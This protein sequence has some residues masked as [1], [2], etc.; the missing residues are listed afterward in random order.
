MALE[1][2]PPRLEDSKTPRTIESG[3][4]RE[5]GIVRALPIIQYE[6]MRNATAPLVFLFAALA[7]GCGGGLVGSP[8]AAATWKVGFW[9]WPGA[10]AAPETLRGH[11]IDD[12]YV[13]VGRVDLSYMNSVSWQ[14]PRAVPEGREYWALWRY[15]P[16]AQP[17]DSQIPIIVRD[18]ALLKKQAPEQGRQVAGIQ[19]DYDCPT[20]E[21]PAYASFLKDLHKQLPE[22]TKVSI[23]ALL[24][25]FRPGTG[26][27]ELVR[28]TAEFVPQFYDVGTS[29][30][31]QPRGIAEPVDPARWGSVFNSLGVPYRLGVSM[32]GRIGIKDRAGKQYFR[33]L[34]P[35]DVLGRPGI[36]STASESTAAGDRRLVLRADRS[37]AVN[38][39]RLDR[40]DEIE[41]ILPTRETVAAAYDGAKRFG[42]FCSGV[43][44]FRW[45]LRDESLVLKPTQVMSWI[46]HSQIAAPPAALIVD[47][48]N[49][50]AVHCWD[51]QLKLHDTLPDHSVAFQIRSTQP[52]EY[53]LPDPKLKGRITVNESSG[54]RL[55]L[56]PYFGVGDL[57]LGRA[58]TLRRAE[59]TVREEK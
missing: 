11:P 17:A 54:L 32:F 7:V 6:R 48:G 56:P 29:K 22:G 30:Q 39:W 15:D 41:L 33:D 18:F 34:T 20:A 28:Q 2:S 47:E 23:T 53:F 14:W 24:D 59:F 44:F 52:L 57:Y 4:V 12:L 31:A 19:L 9:L 21:L 1:S 58:V 13:Q 42:G 45:P 5:F 50:V 55:V 8:Q 38:F 40:G 49:C 3:G 10:A 36:T 43:V 16:P 27:G 25:W 35:L 26:V 51:V 46:A 37:L